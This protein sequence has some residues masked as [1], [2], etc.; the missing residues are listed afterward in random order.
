MARMLSADFQI[1][2][3]LDHMLPSQSVNNDKADGR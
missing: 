1:F 3:L 2:F